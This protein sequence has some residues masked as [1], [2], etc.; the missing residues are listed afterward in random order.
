MPCE[1]YRVVARWSQLERQGEEI[2]R[3]NLEM[4]IEIQHS[5]MVG[6]TRC[7]LIKMKASGSEVGRE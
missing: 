7:I 2:L 6:D 3:R 4:E 5:A 1:T